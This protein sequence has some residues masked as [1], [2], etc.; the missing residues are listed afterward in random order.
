MN[1]NDW[2]KGLDEEFP[3]RSGSAA[4]PQDLSHESNRTIPNGLERKLEEAK[5]RNRDLKIVL[6][7]LHEIMLLLT[8][9]TELQ[10]MLAPLI[11]K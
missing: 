7:G 8:D 11:G 6:A 1:G 5:E 2:A 4:V 10:A 3:F 9:Q